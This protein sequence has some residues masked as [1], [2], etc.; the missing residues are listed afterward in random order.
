MTKGG[1]LTDVRTYPA[2]ATFDY[3]IAGDASY[4]DLRV[5]V[6]GDYTRLVPLTEKGV[7]TKNAIEALIEGSE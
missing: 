3:T 4:D 2:E 6:L 7:F 5:F 1:A